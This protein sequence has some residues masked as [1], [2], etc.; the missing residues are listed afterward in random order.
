MI[1]SAEGGACTVTV[2]VALRAVPAALVAVK[3][4]E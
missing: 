2:R 4:T 1:G 3:R